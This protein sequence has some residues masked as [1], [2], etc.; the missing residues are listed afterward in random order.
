MKTAIVLFNLGGPDS[1]DA[2]EPFLFNLFYDPAIIRLHNPL[3]Y[4]VAKLISS[5]R[6]PKTQGIY[7]L[8]GNQSPLLELTQQQAQALEQQLNAKN[9]DHYKTFIAMRYWHPFAKEAAAQVKAYAPER[10]I[11]L[12]LYPQYSTT[13]TAS[14]IKDWHQAAAQTGLNVP[15]ETI[16]SYPAAPDFIAAHA[17]LL[18]QMLKQLK[19][20]VSAR[21]LFSA[22]G[23]PE[24][25]IKVGDP[26]QKQVEQTVAEVVAVLQAK[27]IRIDYSI[28][29]Q[30]RVGPLK[31]IGPSTEEEIKRAGSDGK[32]I[33]LTPIA[34]VSEHSETLVELDIE[35]KHLAKQA[36]VGHYFR[37]PALGTHPL[38][39]ESLAKLS[40]RSSGA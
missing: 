13:T 19:A 21:V 31:W 27:G 9:Q 23:L 26:Y 20:D 17:D 24:K 25:I 37:V 11:L 12:P 35:Y 4:M 18:M 33:I 6:A 38:F 22:H 5:R 10:I 1:L 2:V 16:E 30:S 15:T 39:I 40:I 8:I 36:G 3:R 28:C 7:K 29:Y 14:S 34:F 32:A